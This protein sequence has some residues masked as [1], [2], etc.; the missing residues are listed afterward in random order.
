M[1]FD[2][3][4]TIIGLRIRIFV[5]TVLLLTYIV[6]TYIAQLIEYPLLGM[7]DILWSVIL[8]TIWL[9][10]ALY[11]MVL[12]Y[13]YVYYSDE[14]ETIVFRYFM[15]GIFGG[16]KN[17]VEINKNS[18]AGYKTEIRYFG[19]MYSVILSQHLREGV[20]NYPPIYLSNLTKKEKNRILNSLYSNSPGE[21]RYVT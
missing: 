21:E 15:A 17:S 8:I 12:N 3:S 9:V 18:F 11:P 14:G 4:K 5:V 6:L 1:T 16:R 10:F 2:N 13:Q 19:L 20:A 7:S